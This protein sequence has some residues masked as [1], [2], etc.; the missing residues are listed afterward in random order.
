MTN[1]L[2]RKRGP[3]FGNS[4]LS[5]EL[6]Q[7]VDEA[8]ETVYLTRQRARLMD[9]VMEIRQRCHAVGL[10]A[11]SRKAITARL[12]SKPRKVLV[13]RREGR[14]AARE[15]EFLEAPRTASHIYHCRHDSLRFLAWLIEG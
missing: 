15:Y 6:D 12:R 13:A 3:T 2:P 11:P 8:I 10:T 9:L 5:D 7:L 4:R 1:L 14:K